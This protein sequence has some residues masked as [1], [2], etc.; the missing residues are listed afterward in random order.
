MQRS[1]GD[2][3]QAQRQPLNPGSLA[4]LMSKIEERIK[5]VIPYEDFD[6]GGI[7]RDERDEW[8]SE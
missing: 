7:L 5:K 6:K 8:L 3:L 2:H 1:G 4:R